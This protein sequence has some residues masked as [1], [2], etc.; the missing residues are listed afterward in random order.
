M[1]KYL[2]NIDLRKFE[3]IE[4]AWN[5]NDLT[6]KFVKEGWVTESYIALK[7]YFNELDIHSVFLVFRE[8]NVI[9]KERLDKK[10]L[11]IVTYKEY[12]R[13]ITDKNLKILEGSDNF[14]IKNIESLELRTIGSKDLYPTVDGCEKIIKIIEWEIS[15]Y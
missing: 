9:Y 7:A 4:L 15:M 2:D 13:W 11:K 6:V 1:I 5:E 10:K 8:N 3:S 14:E 12:L